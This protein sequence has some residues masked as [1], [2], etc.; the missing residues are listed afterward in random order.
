MTAITLCIFALLTGASA[1]IGTNRS[2]MTLNVSEVT[3]NHKHSGR[4]TQEPLPVFMEGGGFDMTDAVRFS[5]EADEMKSQG[6]SQE[7]IQE[8]EQE[9]TNKQHAFSCLLLLLSF[10]QIAVFAMVSS[11]NNLLKKNTW[12]MVD[13]M[14]V[15]IIASTVFHMISLFFEELAEETHHA[16]IMHALFAITLFFVAL[17]GSYRLRNNP[18]LC[19]AFKACIFWMVLLA[20]S[21]AITT[22][23]DKFG[24]GPLHATAV[25]FSGAIFLMLLL[26]VA[27]LIKNKFFADK[28]WYDDVEVSLV[29]G[30]IGGGLAF[31]AHIWLDEHFPPDP[32]PE[33]FSTQQLE[34][35]IAKD[36]WAVITCVLAV[37]LTTPIA[38]MSKKALDAGGYWYPRCLDLLNSVV[39]IL[40]YFAVSVGA[41]DWLAH[42]MGFHDGS[43][44]AHLIA[45][46]TSTFWGFAMI[47]A[48][49]FIPTLRRQA[50]ADGF[51]LA[52]LIL[53]FGG[54]IAGYG[55]AAL[56]AESMTKLNDGWGWSQSKKN[57]CTVA[58]V[59]AL[60]IMAIPVYVKYLNPVVAAAQ[61][62][63]DDK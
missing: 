29:G 14:A 42:R 60:N 32:K 26:L 63:E 23:Q 11:S 2:G 56:I 27:H 62:L 1:R 49:S 43:T 30:A 36:V 48:C 20:K 50:Q 41:G 40:P 55:W 31:L 38:N 46:G 52:A 7:T 61:K 39:G 18:S 54:F 15:V 35:I 34:N 16:V 9:I 44:G 59:L 25:N 21:G 10:T 33:T 13:T 3:D 45:T 24:T 8:Y 19:N 58:S 5:Q 22:A 17:F 37:T 53:G 4:I 47:L 57:M 12:T 6:L 28:T 51:T